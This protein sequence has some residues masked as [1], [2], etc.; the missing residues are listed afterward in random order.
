MHERSNSI[1]LK[2][3]Y[4]S[5]LLEM[6]NALNALKY[7]FKTFRFFYLIYM[8]ILLANEQ[9]VWYPEVR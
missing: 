9:D 2:L 4:L 7:T 8:I 3:C 5:S 1:N 6:K